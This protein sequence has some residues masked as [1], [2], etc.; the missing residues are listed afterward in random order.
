LNGFEVALLPL[1]DDAGE[2]C[3]FADGAGEVES[4]AAAE[5]VVDAGLLFKVGCPDRVQLVGARF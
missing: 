2:C 1:T 4:A 5:L 3:F